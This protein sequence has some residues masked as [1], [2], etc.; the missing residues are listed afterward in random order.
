MKKCP[1]CAE[2]IQDEAIVCRYCGRDIIYS[3]KIKLRLSHGNPNESLAE[4]DRKISIY[5]DGV[6]SL[7]LAGNKEEE[8]PITVGEHVIYAKSDLRE[9]KKYRV[10]CKMDRILKMRILDT[11]NI[12]FKEYYQIWPIWLLE[13]LPVMSLFK[14]FNQ[15]FNKIDDEFR[16]SY[17]ENM[18]YSDNL[19][20]ESDLNK[21]KEI[22]E[23][24]KQ[25]VVN[26]FTDGKEMVL[27]DMTTKIALLEAKKENNQDMVEKLIAET[28]T[29]GSEMYNYQVRN[30]AEYGLINN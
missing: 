1:F 5:I 10:L 13:S 11:P 20:Y 22:P 2:E 4:N 21:L 16:K 18:F 8:I 12:N 25:I 29:M 3:E 6:K 28:I 27:S 19:Y 17:I 7:V 15:I 26:E 23:K 9:S 14:D 30:S 24:L